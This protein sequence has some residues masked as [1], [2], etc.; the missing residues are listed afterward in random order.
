LGQLATSPNGLSY[1]ILN[2]IRKRARTVVRHSPTLLKAVERRPAVHLRALRERST[3][4]SEVIHLDE[5]RPYRRCAGSHDP[6]VVM[7]EAV[8][9]IKAD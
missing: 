3:G 7:I 6:E 9:P 5:K 1:Q 2:V 8:V 4:N